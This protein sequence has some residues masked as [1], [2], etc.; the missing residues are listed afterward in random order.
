MLGGIST[1]LASY[2]AKARGSGEPEFSNLRA[3]ELNTFLRDI[4]AFILDHGLSFIQQADLTVRSF[5]CHTGDESDP[6]FDERIM[7]YRER[8]ELI[9]KTEA[10]D[11]TSGTVYAAHRHRS[12][13]NYPSENQQGMPGMWGGGNFQQGPPPAGGGYGYGYGQLSEKQ[14]MQWKNEKAL[15]GA[16]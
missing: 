4:N 6:K 16:V 15:G 14:Q 3:R 8:F 10:E 13:G 7:R 11:S 1:A 12:P 5:P 9:I 2:L